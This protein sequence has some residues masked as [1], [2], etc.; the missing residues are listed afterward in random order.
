MVNLKGLETD[1]CGSEVI[2]W[3]RWSLPQKKD[4]TMQKDDQ[5]MM[6]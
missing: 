3:I 4:P 6:I 1:T 2:A 5:M